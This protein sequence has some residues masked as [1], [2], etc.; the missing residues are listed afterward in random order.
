MDGIL[1]FELEKG[2]DVSERYRI[3]S[4][5]IEAGDAED[6]PPNCFNIT[7]DGRFGS[8]VNK[9]T[10]DPTG[11]GSNEIKDTV[12]VR[13]WKYVVENSPQFDGRFFCKNI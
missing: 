7:I 6:D 11:V 3:N 10:N 5:D 2:N 1:Y 9:F 12:N 8:D 4:I 13:I